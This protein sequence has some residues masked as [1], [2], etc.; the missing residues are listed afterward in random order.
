MSKSSS[1]TVKELV[2]LALH[3]E[4][5]GRFDEA[6]ALLNAVLELEQENAVAWRHLGALQNLLGRSE[7]S[8][9]CFRRSLAAEANSVDTLVNLGARYFES[10]RADDAID[11]F[12]KAAALQPTNPNS[13]YN[14]GLALRAAG[15]TEDALKALTQACRLDP[16]NADAHFTRAL[17]FLQLDQFEE[18]WQEY[19]WRWSLEAAGQLPTKPPEWQGENFEGKTLVILPEQGHGDTIWASRFLPDVKRRGGSVILQTRH[20]TNLLLARLSGVDGYIDEGTDLADFELFCPIMSVPGLLGITDANTPPAHLYASEEGRADLQPLIERAGDRLKV[21]I[22]WSGSATNIRNHK[23]SAPL[24][25]FVALAQNPD[26]QFYS[27]QKGRCEVELRQQG[28]GALIIEPTN[29]NFAEAA[30]LIE[31]LDLIVMTDS[32]IAHVAGS[33]GRPIWNLLEFQP[34]WIYWTQHE[35]TPWYPSMRLFR[36][37]CSGD[38]LDVFAR[39]DKALKD[40]VRICGE[41]H[42]PE[43]QFEV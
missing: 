19:Q 41:G 43:R 20:E 22:V 32:A 26:V 39:V 28:L 21:G 33:L 36:Q 18:G 14:L 25:Y 3:R 15:R 24:D 42:W 35:R 16:S 12:G 11:I 13:Q 30:A 10:D 29:D 4:R 40:A 9:A 38:W 2:R 8:I 1:K 7:A 6:I 27:L 5:R 31:A 17:L 34:Y 23:R 37:Q